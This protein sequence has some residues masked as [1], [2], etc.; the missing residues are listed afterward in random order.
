MYTLTIVIK[1]NSYF[2]ILVLF[3]WHIFF[4]KKSFLWER[5]EIPQFLVFKVALD[6]CFMCIF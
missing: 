5:R 2:Y 6:F 1:G 4:L 3:N